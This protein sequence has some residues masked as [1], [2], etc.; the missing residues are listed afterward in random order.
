[1]TKLPKRSPDDPAEWLKRAKS[2]LIQAKTTT[3]GVYLEDLCFNAH[4]AVEKA[5]KALLL[6]L[7][8][9]FPFTHDIVRLNTEIEKKLKALPPELA[10]AEF[11]SAYSVASRYP[12]WDEPVSEAEYVRALDAASRVVAWVTA[13]VAGT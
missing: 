8:G 9:K 10:N 1:M 3:E 13:Q 4:Q 2:S 12:G 11:M 6:K 5:L 7:G